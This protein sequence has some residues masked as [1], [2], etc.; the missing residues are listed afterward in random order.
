MS[1]DTSQDIS[2]VSDESGEPEEP[3]CKH[4]WTISSP[5]GTDSIGICKRCG[6]ERSFRNSVEYSVWT[7]RSKF[8]KAPAK[9]A[10]EVNEKDESKE[11]PDIEDVEDVDPVELA[12]VE[13]EAEEDDGK[14]YG[15]TIVSDTDDHLADAVGEQDHD[16]LPIVE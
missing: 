11:I 2:V 6:A 8:S 15:V 10:T 9:D 12:Q 1:D 13:E 3:S 5:E 14:G 16:D 7:S 4:R